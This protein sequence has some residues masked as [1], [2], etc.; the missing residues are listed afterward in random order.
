MSIRFDKGDAEALPYPDA[1]FDVVVS[2]VG[3]MFAPMPDR[4]AAEMLRVCRPGGCIVMAN[5]SPQGFVGQLF[6]TMSKHMPPSPLM[7]SPL[8]WGMEDTV[9]ERFGD[10]VS[11]LTLTKR[12]YPFR[13]ALSPAETTEFYR[14]RAALHG[15]GDTELLQRLERDVGTAVHGGCDEARALTPDDDF[16]GARGHES[17]AREKQSGKQNAFHGFTPRVV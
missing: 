14:K 16:Q 1:S 9:R 3:A 15:V 8:L 12:D 17:D 7:P 10:A 2:L 13:Y 6:K 5:W 11:N 4:V